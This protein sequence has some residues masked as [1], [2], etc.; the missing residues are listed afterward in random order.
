MRVTND[1]GPMQ[2]GGWPKRRTERTPT[3]P[4]SEPGATNAARSPAERAK[5]A[6]SAAAS[7]AAVARNKDAIHREDALRETVAKLIESGDITSAE[8]SA[9]RLARIDEAKKKLEAGAYGRN[10]IIGGIVD[11]LLDQWKI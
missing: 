1:Q 10:D 6:D 11:R 7:D 8:E 4:G 3:A 9:V 2:P 5:K